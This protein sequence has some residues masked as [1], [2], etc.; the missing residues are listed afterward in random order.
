VKPASDIRA[1][2][3]AFHAR[4]LEYLRVGLD[5]I[6]AAR[7]IVETAGALRGPALDVGTG[8]GLLA[9]ELARKGMSVVSV[10]VDGDEQELAR[11]LAQE[12]GVAS[13]VT[14]VHGDA[15]HLPY[16]DGSFG[17]VAMMD[18]LHHLDEPGPVLREM[19]RVLE[20]AGRIIVADFDEQGFDL[21]AGVHRGEGREHPRT[22]TTIGHAMTELEKAGCRSLGH[23]NLAL[24]DV[25]VLVKERS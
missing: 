24:H 11:F 17:C 1:R 14:L 16:P 12:A 15:A 6:G 2:L 18:V 8:K 22:A 23:S 4:N 10:D 25:V 13:R 19:A 3:R 20:H 21:V 7:L 5:R 9:I